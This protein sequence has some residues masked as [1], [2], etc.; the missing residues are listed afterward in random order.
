MME[1]MHASCV[2]FQG[3][4]ILLR[5]T[6]GVGKSDLALRLIDRHGAQLVADDQTCLEVENE[7]LYASAPATLKGW[8]QVTNIG[9]VQ[10]PACV[11]TPLAAVIDLVPADQRDALPLIALNETVTILSVALPRVQLCAFDI[12]A[13]EKISALLEILQQGGLD[14]LPDFNAK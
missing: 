5:G 12:S 8:L 2:Q 9:F 3:A 10:R 6:A 14:S 11:R 7:Q 4:G 13:P 1:L